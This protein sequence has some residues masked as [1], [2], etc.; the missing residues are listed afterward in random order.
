MSDPQPGVNAPTGAPGNPPPPA[1]DSGKKHR[2][3]DYNLTAKL[4]QGAGF[5]CFF[6]RAC[7]DGLGLL[8]RNQLGIELGDETIGLG[9]SK[10]SLVLCVCVVVCQGVLPQRSSLAHPCFALQL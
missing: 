3:G 10:Y 7:Q 2:L 5:L 1:V 9:Q 8:N 4:G 6:F